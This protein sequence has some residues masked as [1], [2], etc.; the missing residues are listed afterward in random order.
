MKINNK[1]YITMYNYEWKNELF[2]QVQP[3]DIVFAKMPLESKQLNEIEYNH[4][5]R[6]YLVVCRNDNTLFCYQCS[7]KPPAFLQYKEYYCTK[8]IDEEDSYILFHRFFRIPLE[9]VI[10]IMCKLNEYDIYHIERRLSLKNH[11]YFT[12]K[13]CFNY[14][15]ENEIGDIVIYNGEIG[16]IYRKDPNHYYIYPVSYQ[17]QEDTILHELN[18]NQYYI[19][20]KKEVTI[21]KTQVLKIIEIS[22]YQNIN[23][24]NNLKNLIEQKR[25]ALEL[26]RKEIY[27]KYPCGQVKRIEKNRYFTY[28]YSIKNK[29]YGFPIIG[30]K[31]L[32]YIDNVIDFEKK[33][34]QEILDPDYLV[35]ILDKLIKLEKDEHHVFDQIIYTYK[36]IKYDY[37]FKMNQSLNLYLNSNELFEKINLVIEN[38][39]F[40]TKGIITFEKYEVYPNNPSIILYFDIQLH[41]V[42]FNQIKEYEKII[43]E[44]SNNE[45]IIDFSYNVYNKLN[46]NKNELIRKSK[47]QYFYV[48]L[49][50]DNS[51]SKLKEDA[52]LLL[53]Y[54]LLDN[55]QR[56]FRI[57]TNENF[58]IELLGNDEKY[59]HTQ[60]ID[61]SYIFVLE[62]NKE[63]CMNFMKTASFAKSKQ[64]SILHAF[65][66]N[67]IS[68]LGV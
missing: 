65:V 51:H 3:M 47:N 27:F 1:N 20:D 14:P 61:E 57:T 44:C 59:V 31:I 13:L 34:P 4:R 32:Y 36:N 56:V 68:I 24:F 52:N 12:N 2:K 23:T 21:K 10:K 49:N 54:C 45:F 60:N 22:S 9:N 40:K 66:Y 53:D 16:Y 7:S 67:R 11:S 18:G 25:K 26:R 8:N 46:L 55:M 33:K 37:F 50:Y 38:V 58:K 43:Y 30:N 6:P 15:I 29:D 63:E 42:T 35:E 28:L 19:N 17:I 64:I 41:K 62:K 5:F 39:F 48:D